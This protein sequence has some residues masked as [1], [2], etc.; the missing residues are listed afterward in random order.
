M[1]D[2]VS[3]VRNGG[4][5]RAG[6]RCSVGVASYPADATDSAELLLA[7]DRALYAAKHAGRDRISTAAEGLALASDF[8]PPRTPVDEMGPA[9]AS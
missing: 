3:G 8:V 4:R 2:A 9:P 6:A 1:R 7:A 5:R